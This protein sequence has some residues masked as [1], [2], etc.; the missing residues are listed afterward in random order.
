M[1]PIERVL[2]Y[3]RKNAPHVIGPIEA[4][5]INAGLTLDLLKP[6]RF[7]EE[8]ITAALLGSLA[9]GLPWV[10]PL[11]PTR[12]KEETEIAWGGFSKAATDDPD[13]M[14][15]SEYGADFALALRL[16][17]DAVRV[18]LFQAKRPREGRGRRIP[19]FKSS[20][21]ALVRHG[22]FKALQ[23]T[24]SEML[25]DMGKPCAF[26]DLHW[27]HYLGYLKNGPVCV[28]M[29]DLDDFSVAVSNAVLD[30]GP[31]FE[32][33]EK[34]RPLLQLLYAGVAT[35][36][37]HLCPGWQT[38]TVTEADEYLPHLVPLMPVFAADES[39]GGGP[40]LKLEYREVVAKASPTPSPAPTSTP[41]AGI[42]SGRTRKNSM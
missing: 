1:E 14:T 29:T 32:V 5:V 19:V 42:K 22:Q 7:D 41:Q 24:A 36:A 13:A 9:G 31:N 30:V 38:L 23:D 27:I 34:A 2:A 10:A 33:P 26:R 3:W 17:E 8:T 25:F 20:S 18:A 16:G 15:E 12:S 4:A 40:A 35:P 28:P 37:G 39:G 11:V 21:D 6:D